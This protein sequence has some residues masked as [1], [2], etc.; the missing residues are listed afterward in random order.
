MSVIH[1]P[2]IFHTHLAET[3][4]SRTASDHSVASAGTVRLL[5]SVRWSGIR[6]R[7]RQNENQSGKKNNSR[8]AEKWATGLQ[9]F[10]RVVQCQQDVFRV[11]KKKKL[12]LWH[13]KWKNGVSSQSIY[14]LYTHMPHIL[15]PWHFS[16]P[17][18]NTGTEYTAQCILGD[19][20][21][22]CIN[23]NLSNVFEVTWNHLFSTGGIVTASCSLY[24]LLWLSL[25]VAS[26]R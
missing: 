7:S 13:F 19:P 17:Y 8:A 24:T 25:T 6:V 21:C 4:I 5:C 23:A 20:L 22:I 15:Q 1:A 16:T 14:H 26:C 9:T 12:C 2:I 11:K 10:R 3:H 18:A